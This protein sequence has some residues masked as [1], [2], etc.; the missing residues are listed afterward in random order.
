MSPIHCQGEKK[1][2]PRRH[3]F[4]DQ[5]RPTATIN[6]RHGAERGTR[7]RWPAAPASLLLAQPQRPFCPYPHPPPQHTLIK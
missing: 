7:Q 2:L 3:P 5:R 6:K 1:K 4:A